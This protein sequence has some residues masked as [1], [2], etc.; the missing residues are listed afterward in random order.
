MKDYYKSVAS[1]P[2]DDVHSAASDVI[3]VS[4]DE[5]A[6]HAHKAILSLASP[7]FKDMFTLPQP[8]IITSKPII[9]MAEDS[10]MLD[11]ILRFCYPCSRSVL[12]RVLMI[13]VRKYLMDD[14]ARRAR[15]ELRK[16]VQKEPL[17][18]FAIA[19]S[20]QWKE[21]I[22]E[23][24]KWF[25]SRPLLDYDARDIAE[26]DALDSARVLFSLFK[27]HRE[28]SRMSYFL[29]Q[30]H[31]FVASDVKYLMNPYLEPRKTWL[32]TYCDYVAKTLRS[33][34]SIHALRSG[35]EWPRQVARQV[36]YACPDCSKNNLDNIFGVWIPQCYLNRIEEELMQV[37]S[38]LIC[39]T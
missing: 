8:M 37:C 38:L 29:A 32:V 34:P 7:F 9:S 25:L 2:F 26:L 21:E 15:P 3:L 30:D 22:D 16:Y 33:V 35:E 12:F 28:C 19:Y 1:H 11:K 39:G 14:V 4:S 18:V 13:M 36:A 5:I 24:V 23:A 6:F 20:F 31:E 10:E 17:R 27:F